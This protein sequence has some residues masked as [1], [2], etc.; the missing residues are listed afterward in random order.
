MN[1]LGIIGGSGLYSMEGL[2]DSKWIKLDTPWGSPSDEILQAKL[3]GKEICFLPRH[4]RG[5]KI[6]PSNINFRANID[7]L[8]QLGVTDIISMSA[9]GS[10]K[11]NL[12]PG[13]FVIVDQF[14]DRTFARVK[15]FFDKEIVAHVSMAKPTSPGL[16]KTCEKVL[17]KLHIPFQ[18]GGTYLVMEGPQ[19]SSLA[20]SN[21]YRSWGADVIGMTNMPEAKLARE[22]EI[23]YA[24]IAMVTDFDCWHPDHE[25][26]SVEQVVKTLLGNAEKAKKVVAELLLSFEADIDEKDP[27]NKCLD[28]AIITDKKVWTKETLN[29]LSTIAGRVLNK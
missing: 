4:A 27:A 13:K 25:D 16:M 22:A 3:N 18:K 15:T 6:N 14:I 8:K 9:V 7:A 2:E 21:L 12:E 5:H 20:E 10:L 29:N 24:T 17:K 28:V 26:V 23:R 19:F 1:K 11:E